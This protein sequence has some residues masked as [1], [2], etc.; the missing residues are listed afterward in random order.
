MAQYTHRCELRL[1]EQEH[2]DLVRK[3]EKAGLQT[4][5]DQHPYPKGD[6]RTAAKLIP[7]AHKNT[8]CTDCMQR[9]F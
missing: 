1:T 3:A 5:A 9:V 8:P 2:A 7:T 4:A 6:Q